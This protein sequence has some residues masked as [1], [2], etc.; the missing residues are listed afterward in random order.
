[1]SSSDVPSWRP[2]ATLLW[3][4]SSCTWWAL[5]PEYAPFLIFQIGPLLRK[6]RS[7]LLFPCSLCDPIVLRKHVHKASNFKRRS[8]NSNARTQ[9]LTI[10]AGL[11]HHS[12]M[13]IDLFKWHE[14]H[15]CRGSKVYSIS[16]RVEHVQPHFEQN[17]SGFA[18]KL[19]IVLV[20][21]S[22]RF[23]TWFMDLVSCQYVCIFWPSNVIYS[24][25]GKSH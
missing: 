6:I 5:S 1:M 12:H 11:V 14:V 4:T 3:V 10:L 23:W 20:Y 19:S 15:F 13:K 2:R 25:T 9:N 24:R 17:R 22:T 16:T 7:F 21:I 8:L 18:Q